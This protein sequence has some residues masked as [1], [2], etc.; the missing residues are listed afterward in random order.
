MYSSPTLACRRLRRNGP[1]LRCRPQAH[2]LVDRL[3]RHR[4][5]AVGAFVFRQARPP[6]RL[7]VGAVSRGA[8]TLRILG[9]AGGRVGFTVP[10]SASKFAM[11]KSFVARRVGIQCD[12]YQSVFQVSRTSNDGSSIS[13]SPRSASARSSNVRSA[14]SRLARTSRSFVALAAARNA[15]KSAASPPRAAVTSTTSTSSGEIAARS[16]IHA[17]ASFRASA[18]SA[19]S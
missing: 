9:P 8:E 12:A 16:P 3:E 6:E 7:D 2:A 1:K 19:G 17:S 11:R 14:S 5:L 18:E 10:A 15:S 4:E 13:A